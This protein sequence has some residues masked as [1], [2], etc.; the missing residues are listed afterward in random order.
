MNTNGSL[1]R[2]KL[3]TN[4]QSRLPHNPDAERAVLGAILLDG[5]TVNNT[6]RTALEHVNCGDFLVDSHR[7]I[8]QRMVAMA[9]AAQVIDLVTLCDELDRHGE[10]EIYIRA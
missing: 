3:E 7:A 6:L 8:F 4:E 2:T 1:D 9:E 5:S 10:L